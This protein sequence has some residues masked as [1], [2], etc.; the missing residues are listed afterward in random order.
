MPI[1]GRQFVSLLCT[2]AL[3][4][5]LFAVAGASAAA[6]EN[7]LPNG[8]FEEGLWDAEGA[9]SAVLDGEVK[10]SGMYSVKLAGGAAPQ[11]LVAKPVPVAAGGKYRLSLWVKADGLTIANGL[12]MA[13]LE[14]NKDNGAIGWYQPERIISTGGTHDWKQVAFDLEHLNPA[15]ANLKLYLRMD[16]DLQGTA[17]VDGVTVRPL[18]APIPADLDNGDFENGIWPTE[19]PAAIVPDT[20]IYRSGSASAKVTAGS[21]DQLMASNPVPVDP[22][23]RYSLS[24]W[25]KTD[26]I[27]KEDGVSIG[28]LEVDRHNGAIG[29]YQSDRLLATGGTH[30]WKQLAAT[31][32]FLNANT[33][34][35]KIYLRV[36][37]GINGT[38]WFDLVELQ[39]LPA[40]EEPVGIT[41]SSPA[42][43]NIFERNE[44]MSGSVEISNNGNEQETGT[45]R[46]TVKDYWGGVSSETS[47]PVSIG[48]GEAYRNTIEFPDTEAGYY[49]VTASFA[50]ADGSVLE[51]KAS[52]ASIAGHDASKTPVT[53][54]FGTQTHFGQYKADP[55]VNIPLISGMGGKFIRD[56]MYWSE[57]EK[58]KG[59]FVFDPRFDAYVEAANDSG[60]EP[61]LILNYGNALY[62]KNPA[63]GAMRSPHTREGLEA[64]SRYVK[65]VVTRYKGKIRYYEVWNEP[66]GNQFWLAPPDGKEYAAAL[67]AA[68]LE[69]KKADPEAFVIAGAVAGTDLY[70]LEELF[71]QGGLDYMD[72][73]SIHP[74][75]GGSPERTKYLEDIERHR[76]LM[77][78]YGALKE[79]WITETGYPTSTGY[80][81]NN[82]QA[83]YLVRYHV[84]SMSSGF[85]R[86]ID[87]YDFQDDGPDIHQHEHNF[88]LVRLDLTPKPAFVA[89]HAMVD[90]L[91]GAVYI[92]QLPLP[93][94]AYGYVFLRNGKTVYALWSASGKGQ[95]SLDAAGRAELTD[96]FGRTSTVSP[97]DGKVDVAV[98]PEPVYLEVEGARAAAAAFKT[99]LQPT[100][101]KEL[102][103]VSELL[104]QAMVE[105]DL[106]AKLAE[107]EAQAKAMTASGQYKQAADAIG[108][109]QTE[110]LRHAGTSGLSGAEA[111][112]IAQ[113]LSMTLQK[114]AA[115]EAYAKPGLPQEAAAAE[116]N[117]IG[118]AYRK[119]VQSAEAK[120][121]PEGELPESEPFRISLETSLAQ[122]RHLLDVGDYPGVRIQTSYADRLLSA[123]EQAVDSEEVS[124]PGVWTS[125]DRYRHSG[126]RT[127][128]VPLSVHNELDRTVT[129]MPVADLPAGL[130]AQAD[131]VTLQAGEAATVEVA[132]DGSGVLTGE[133]PIVLQVEYASADGNGTIRSTPMNSRIEFVQPVQLSILPLTAEF[134]RDGLVTVR[135]TNLLDAPV[136]GT[137]AIQPNELLTFEQ[138]SAPLDGLAAGGSKD[139]VFQVKAKAEVHLNEYPLTIV[140]AV[141]GSRISYTDAL[142]FETAVKGTAV[143]DGSLD[144]WGGAKPVHLN[145]AG[146]V[147]MI[148]D[149]TPEDL[150]ATVWTMWDDN[151]FYFAAKVTDDD[152]R[153][154]YSNDEVWR[155]DGFQAAFDTRL[156]RTQSYNEDDYEYGFSRTPEG[157]QVFRWVAA[158]DRPTGLVPGAL[159]QVTTQADGT[160]IYE[161]AIPKDEISPLPL[162]AGTRFGFNFLLNE[163]DGG[164][165]AGWLEWAEGIGLYK[166]P[167]MFREWTLSE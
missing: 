128:I 18:E 97:V 74:Y 65:E 93:A 118:N 133:Y 17:W 72:A 91:A 77:L 47:E 30:D 112:G 5:S 116:L 131:P 165:R 73:L 115:G 156:D 145:R 103:N 34:M 21:Q 60:V 159:L 64:Y 120:A 55:R 40:L 59:N 137:V 49:E 104:A 76:T 87:W 138:A 100:V 66:N 141:N 164:E 31:L 110:L 142:D 10:M 166:N 101:L 41:I 85:I 95:I 25:V 150:Q 139:L 114:A 16:G 143:I 121:G 38:A 79:L 162:A 96:L 135:V 52:F 20:G 43:G 167:S 129:A 132:I 78:K 117:R 157:P 14:V 124:H 146:Q 51:R 75:R 69:I 86:M 50:I 11:I 89:Y 83:Q 27:G 68:Y 161:A 125:L 9:T 119:A 58:A 36:D 62:D 82:Q 151:Y 2:F 53:S 92:G 155:G 15:T 48:P 35:I 106:G 127:L 158:K 98:G 4:C 23:K 1:R 152:F 70:F 160:M 140:A 71:K 61:I 46:M 29:W 26:G 6:E 109:L 37:G 13:A 154:V 90:K 39:E 7:L 107:L 144:D 130:Q 81:T 149:W 24:A 148:K 123:W 102:D 136:S 28:V 12:Y 80:Y 33:V 111:A 94:D 67:K 163:N 99:A 122:A 56:E 63:T 105:G 108:K 22:A 88:G 19:G 42:T 32:D 44:P 113:N 153:Q 57:V 126:E 147:H 84:Q 3:L 45:V 54:F 8:G 134:E